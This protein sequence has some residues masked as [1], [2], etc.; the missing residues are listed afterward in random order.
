ML[1][2]AHETAICPNPPIHSFTE[3]KRNLTDYIQTNTEANYVFAELWGQAMILEAAFWQK[4]T[5]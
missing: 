5:L 3:D 1:H 4:E 2:H